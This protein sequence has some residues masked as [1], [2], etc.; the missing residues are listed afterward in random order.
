MALEQGNPSAA[1]NLLLE[2]LAQE[3][4]NI[5]MTLA[6]AR[7]WV[8]IGDYDSAAGLLTQLQESEAVALRGLIHE[9]NEQDAQAMALY[10]SLA[11]AQNLPSSYQLRYAVL[12]ENNGNTGLARQWYQHYLT[13]PEQA[14]AARQF[15]ASR[16][17]A[18][19]S[20]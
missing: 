6:F 18:L 16:I 3:P 11:A 14:L 17:Q 15:A 5:A 7:F 8:K 20:Q 10:Q 2:A 12:L 19:I 4:N 13:L 9:L 1:E